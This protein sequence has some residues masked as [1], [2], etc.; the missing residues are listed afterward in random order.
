MDAQLV[1]GLLGAAAGGLAATLSLGGLGSSGGPPRGAPVAGLPVDTAG[2]F[3]AGKTAVIT[4]AG[5]GI[6]R[7][8][9]IR[10]ASLG[11]NVSA[12]PRARWPSSDRQPRQTATLPA[13]CS[14]HSRRLRCWLLRWTL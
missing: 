7:A 2:V 5:S 12:P 3:A 10:C 6:G 9:A 1:T 8:T 11:M 14:L 4:G 13:A